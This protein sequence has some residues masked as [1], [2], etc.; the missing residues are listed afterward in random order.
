MNAY[1][2]QY[3]TNQVSTATP[4]QILIMLYDGAIRFVSQADQ[5]IVEGK[6]DKKA[7][8]INKTIAIL[9]ELSATLDHK[10]GGQISENLAALY[11]FMTRELNKSNM[12][13]DRKSL[14][15]VKTLMSELRE[16][17]VQA[18]EINRREK[19]GTATPE[20]DKPAAVTVSINI[21]S[22]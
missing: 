17:W 6:P 8:Y 18:I 20:T 3:Q 7:L 5:A 4:E 22:A 16:T 19:A 12:R 14:E 11:D 10:V 15:V 9:A 1:M 13:N 2:S 21:Q